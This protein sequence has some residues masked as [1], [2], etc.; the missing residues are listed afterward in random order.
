MGIIYLIT[1][2]KASFNADSHRLHANDRRLCRRDNLRVSALD[3][4]KSAFE[5]GFSV[6]TT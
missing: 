1:A 3:L 4:R 2:E 6:L 5:M